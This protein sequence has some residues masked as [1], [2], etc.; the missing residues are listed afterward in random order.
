MDIGVHFVKRTYALEG[1]EALALTCLDRISTIISY[2]NDQLHTW[3]S[4]Y[5]KVVLVQPSCAASE[6][7]FSILNNCFNTKQQQS[8]QDLIE[9]SII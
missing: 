1:D 4:S 7:V 9:A 3:Y 8:L 6:R 5:Q 2:Q